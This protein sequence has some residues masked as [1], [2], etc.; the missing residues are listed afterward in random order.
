MKGNN[1]FRSTLDSFIFSSVYIAIGATLMAMQTDQL[2]HLPRT[3]KY[4]LYFIFFSTM[5]SYNLHWYL[6]PEYSTESV[7]VQW[8]HQNKDLHLLFFAAGL[9]GSFFFFLTL[10]PFIEWLALGAVLTFLYTAPKIERKP[11]VHLKKIAIGKTIYLAFVWMYA[12]TIL[13]FIISGEKWTTGFT[14]F[15]VARFFFI[16]AICIIFDYR[17]REEDKQHKI[18]SLITYLNEK[19]INR[20]FAFS[21]LVYVASTIA[22][23]QYGVSWLHITMLLIPGI[24]TAL[25]YPYAKKNFSDYLYYLFLDGLM[26]LPSILTLLIR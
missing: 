16:Y 23:T 19:G 7:R 12:T 5:C 24:I 20:L 9:M 18:R 26:F 8:T 10:L 21:L 2:F 15:A 3:E 4:Y 22:T 1:F 14:L 11:F 25:I 6:T 17:D 13:P